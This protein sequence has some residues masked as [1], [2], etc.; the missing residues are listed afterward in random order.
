MIINIIAIGRNMPAWVETTFHEYQKRLP[1]E[2][3]IKL[4]EL[5]LIKRSKNISAEK[6]KQ[7]EAEQILKAI[8][9]KSLIIALDEHGKEKTTTELATQ[10]QNWR[11]N[12]SAVTLLIGGPDGLAPVCRQ[13]AQETWSLGKLTFPHPLVRIILAEQLY[14]AWSILNNHPYHRE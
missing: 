8:P 1:K 4:I 7:Q 12:Y 11:E 10:L 2:L 5:P 13:T 9:E 6:I 3:Q 14:R